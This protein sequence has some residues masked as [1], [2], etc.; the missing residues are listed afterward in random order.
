MNAWVLENVFFIVISLSGG[1]IF[2]YITGPSVE[3][4]KKGLE[5]VTSMLINFILFVWAGKVMM[6]L[7]LF[8]SDPL[9]VLAYPS[10][11][12]AFYTAVLLTVVTIAHRI[13]RQTLQIR[14]F[15]AA[16][17]PIFLGAAFTYEFLDF[18]WRNNAIA[19][20]QA[21][22]LLLLMVVFILFQEKLP[23]VTMTCILF[24]GWSLG[25]LILSFI[26]PYTSLFG[27]MMAAWFLSLLLI[28]SISVFIY[29]RRKVT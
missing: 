15:L 25:Q 1:F 13:K 14:E 21:G 7:P 22:L 2:Y 10:A 12:P 23:P 20:G 27:Y 9:A 11:S 26:L 24:A 16:F 18:V 6:N 17:L 29:N 19:L 28:T 5:A 4:K 8:I 3:A